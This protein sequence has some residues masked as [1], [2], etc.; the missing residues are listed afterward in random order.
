M[1]LL[2]ILFILRKK[3]HFILFFEGGFFAHYQKKNSSIFR[4]ICTSQIYEF[5][6]YANFL[7]LFLEK[8]NTTNHIKLC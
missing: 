7:V 5:L 6:D 1:H 2:Y 8:K 3:I 4:P